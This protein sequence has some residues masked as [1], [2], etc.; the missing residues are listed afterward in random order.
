[1][2]FAT[3]ERQRKNVVVT[4][5][6]HAPT[7]IFRYRGR[8]IEKSYRST[9]RI[10]Q[11]VTVR[12]LHGFKVARHSTETHGFIDRRLYLEAGVR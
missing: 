5:R 6:K 10:L 9:V 8:I 11:N 3:Q 7:K 2:Y 12:V 1:M 4:I